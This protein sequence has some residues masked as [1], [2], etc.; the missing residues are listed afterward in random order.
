MVSVSRQCP[1][2]LHTQTLHII[3]ENIGRC[4]KSRRTIVPDMDTNGDNVSRYNRDFSRLEYFVQIVSPAL[5]ARFRIHMRN[6]SLPGNTH[7]RYVRVIEPSWKFAGV[8]RETRI[9]VFCLFCVI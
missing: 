2:I 6:V 3:S 9:S 4:N 1:E 8:I 7:V 5:T